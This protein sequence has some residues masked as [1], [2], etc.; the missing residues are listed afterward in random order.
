M[1]T[2]TLSV[3][4]QK[5]FI[6]CPVK[7]PRVSARIESLAD[8]LAVI[9]ST[10][11]TNDRFWFRG[12]YDVLFS[13]TPS[14]LRYRSFAERT[15]ALS[16]LADFKR[17]ADTKLTRTPQ[18]DEELEWALIAQHYGLP[19][20]LLDWTES[21]TTALYFAC[22]KEDGDGTVFVLNP[23]DLNRLSY[24]GKPRILDPQQ[25]RDL[26]LS[27]LRMSARKTKGGRKPI[28][29]NPVWNSARLIMQKGVFTLHGKKVDL[30]DARI[31]SL[32]AIPVL[33]EAKLTLRAELQ[34]I[35]VD[36]MTL[37]PELEHSCAHLKRN[38]GLEP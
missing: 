3:A 29:I 4:E 5:R 1:P 2:K 23:I 7:C 20:R 28:A 13:L 30:D 14:A 11:T 27:Y 25:D 15:R 9:S 16:L 19:T 18:P 33:R 37:F 12:H 31:P 26:I 17:I 36:E 32:V 24:P 21:A 22:I 35:G 6:K 34:R 8:F 10:I 38:A